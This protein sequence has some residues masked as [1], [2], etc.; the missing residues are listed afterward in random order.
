MAEQRLDVAL[1][2]RG[3]TPSRERAQEA[4]AAGLV[5][6]NGKPGAKPALKV[7]EADELAVTGDPIGY[8]GRGGLK[9]EGALERFAIDPAGLICMD[10]GAS[11]GGF[12]DC[13]LQRGARLVYAV[14]VGRDQLHPDLRKD[15]RVVVMEATDIRKVDGL[16][17]PPALCAVDVSFISLTLVLPAVVRLAA[18]GGLIVALIKPQFEVGPGGVGKKG[19]VRDPREHRKAVDKVLGAATA[20][21]LATGLVI[22]SP[23]LG[24]EGNREFLTTFRLGG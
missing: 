24:T 1:V 11:T 23:V 18:P 20:L 14:D 15:P 3:L 6:V 17:E 10:V 7:T 13:L 12:T 21:G 9:L 5:L 19:I 4:I 8:V 22:D 2:Q 16:P